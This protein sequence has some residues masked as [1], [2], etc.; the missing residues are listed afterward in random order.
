[1]KRRQLA[2]AIILALAPLAVPAASKEQTGRAWLSEVPPLPHDANAAF[3]QWNY[4][5]GGSLT[6]G[7][8]WQA[9]DADV[10]NLAADQAQAAADAP[11][12]FGSARGAMGPGDQQAMATMMAVYGSFGQSQQQLTDWA[13]GPRMQLLKAWD[14]ESQDLDSQQIQE[15]ARLPACHNEAGNPSGLALASLA[16]KYDDQRIQA[17]TKYLGQAIPVLDQLKTIVGRVID[18]VDSARAAWAG[19]QSQ[20]LKQ[21]MA[22]QASAE[23]NLSIAQVQSV[24]SF[25]QELSKRAAQSVARR[26]DDERNYANA[27]GC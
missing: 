2:L 3:S 6:E 9:F 17:A 21:S 20:G 13:S 25:V 7:S 11:S 15:R 16:Y 26:K 22:A 12:D 24:A 1:M 10:K 18:S 27:G 23:Q 4:Q 19:M 8:G 14:A 5:P